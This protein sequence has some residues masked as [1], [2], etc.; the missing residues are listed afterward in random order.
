MKVLLME[1]NE[2][3]KD[4]VRIP[5]SQASHLSEKIS[6]YDEILP[7]AR[8]GDYDV[9][10]LNPVFH[11]VDYLRL[12][13][14]LR[15]KGINTPILYVAFSSTVEGRV[16]ALDNGADDALSRPFATEELSARLRAL[17]RRRAVYVG[18]K[19]LVGD[20]WFNRRLRLIEKDGKQAKLRGKE[21]AVME[22]FAFN[23]EQVIPKSKFADK[24]W[25]YDSEAEY[26]NVEVYV[27]FLR[28]KLR[29]VGSRLKIASVRD[30][31]YFLDRKD[32]DELDEWYY[33]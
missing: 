33:Q 7:Y 5:V 6:E 20:I 1:P 12:I 24:I 18:D 27:S 29:S 2:A 23:S 9:I 30:V 25:G 32:V 28:K 11:T 15:K 3:G 17:A 26:N 14:R 31:G 13:T 10:V 16:M 21:F 22:M 8:T 4:S 19:F